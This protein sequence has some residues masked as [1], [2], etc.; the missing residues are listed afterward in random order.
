MGHR[1][2]PVS[3]FGHSS[4]A[5]WTGSLESCLHF[6]YHPQLTEGLHISRSTHARQYKRTAA[7]S[8][9]Q[10]GVLQV[11]GRQNMDSPR[12]YARISVRN[13]GS[14]AFMELKKPF[15]TDGMG[16]CFSGQGIHGSMKE[17]LKVFIR[18]WRIR[19][20]LSPATRLPRFFSHSPVTPPDDQKAAR[21]I[22]MFEV[23]IHRARCDRE[24]I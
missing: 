18:S 14:G 22:G 20:S 24:A 13:V 3:V 7:S 15:P 10:N 11:T 6:R 1:T 5:T 4:L 17:P 12:I 19:G 9:A 8:G 2:T 16:D 23:Q 21:M